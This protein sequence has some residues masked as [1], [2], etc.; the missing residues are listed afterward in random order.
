MRTRSQTSDTRRRKASSPPLSPISELSQ[1]GVP[2]QQDDGAITTSEKE[3]D[4]HVRHAV[5]PE[6]HDRQTFFSEDAQTQGGNELDDDSA[7]LPQLSLT[8]PPARQTVFLPSP[9]QNQPCSP[10]VDPQTEAEMKRRFEE[11][12]RLGESHSAALGLMTGGSQ[13][14]EVD[15]VL[16]GEEENVLATEEVPNDQYHSRQQER[17]ATKAE[18]EAAEILLHM[19]KAV[20]P[21]PKPRKKRGPYKKKSSGQNGTSAAQKTAEAKAKASYR[22]KAVSETIVSSS[23]SDDQTEPQACKIGARSPQVRF[24]EQDDIRHFDT[25][26]P[27]NI[28]STSSCIDTECLSQ[29]GS[30]AKDAMIVRPQSPIKIN[31]DRVAVN[32]SANTG[33]VIAGPSNIGP[34]ILRPSFDFPVN[35]PN[36]TTQVLPRAQEAP[37]ERIAR[38][39][40]WLMESVTQRPAYISALVSE[41]D[42]R[43]LDRSGAHATSIEP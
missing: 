10:S 5:P 23:S 29:S 42:R 35:I 36:V 17:A 13:G 15:S 14:M 30:T 6:S 24:A 12:R 31:M 25:E 3:N 2:I 38:L 27:T 7:A 33:A 43:R 4:R 9:Q 19:R 40:D 1:N 22:K 8:P 32:T 21:V 34:P 28:A 37:R 20:E 26:G 18:T 39:G 11:E 41:L 16:D